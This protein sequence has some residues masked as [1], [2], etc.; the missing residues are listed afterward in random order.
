MIGFQKKSPWLR[1]SAGF[2][3]ASSRGW[4]LPANPADPL[5]VSKALRPSKP[6][7]TPDSSCTVA[8]L[9]DHLKDYR[10]E[11]KRL[12]LTSRAQREGFEGHKVYQE[13]KR[14]STETRF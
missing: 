6:T 5:Q 4:N 10:A 13:G 3:W 8:T 7:G 11:G 12:L 2:T 14:V 1:C 9:T